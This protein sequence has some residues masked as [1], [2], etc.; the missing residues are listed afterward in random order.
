MRLALALLVLGAGLAT[1]SA[2]ASRCVHNAPGMGDACLDPNG[3]WRIDTSA[4]AAYTH[5]PDAGLWSAFEAPIHPH[6]VNCTTDRKVPHIELFYAS[7]SDVTGRFTALRSEIISMMEA[8]NGLLYDEARR[9]GRSISLRV[10]CSAGHPSI[11][12]VKLRTKKAATNF[13]SLVTDMWDFG[14]NQ[15]QTKYWVWADQTMGALAGIGTG[16]PD[17]K[18]KALNPNMITPG[19]SAIWGHRLTQGGHV[20]MLHEGSHNFGGV[21]MS[22]PHTTGNFHCTDG[23]D[24]MCYPDGGPYASR[25]STTA[26]STRVAYDCRGDDYFNPVPKSGSH[27]SKTWNLG[28]P[29][30]RYFAGCSYRTG[31]LTAPLAGQDPEALIPANDV[32]P[33]AIS[34]R[35]HPVSS[36]CAGHRF[37]IIG[38]PAVAYD[39]REQWRT[40]LDPV[41]RQADEVRSLDPGDELWYNAP[42]FDLDVC[43][44]KGVTL[45]RCYA[46][47]TDAGTVPTG[48]TSVRVIL[49]AGADAGYVFSAL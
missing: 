17:D 22:A 29:Y 47:A 31:A 34:S 8:A 37:A 15:P 7:A 32:H 48:T 33:P 16:Y 25:Y 6:A 18:L 19:Y 44:Y 26:C 23:F 40:T 24:I 42:P 49:A 4:G 36:T 35:A 2:P 14:Y 3:M 21:P 13:V 43:F 11:T 10:L 41:R 27:L 20:T 28:L 9:Y 30:N 46:G 38:W 45:L 5:G 12:Q 1:N 39:A